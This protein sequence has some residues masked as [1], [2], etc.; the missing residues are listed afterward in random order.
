MVVGW[1][2][3]LAPGR[4][5][6]PPLPPHPHPPRPPPH[7]RAHAFSTGLLGAL[8]RAACS[9]TTLAPKGQATIKSKSSWVSH[10]PA[11]WGGGGA[12][13]GWGWGLRGGPARGG[14]AQCPACAPICMQHACA[15]RLVPDSPPATPAKQVMAS[16]FQL[17]PTTE[18]PPGCRGVAPT[19][20]QSAGAP[21]SRACT[22]GHGSDGD[23][24][25]ERELAVRHATLAHH[26]A[27]TLASARPPPTLAPSLLP[28]LPPARAAHR[29]AIRALE[30][31]PAR[32]CKCL[33]PARVCV[34]GGGGGGPAPGQRAGLPARK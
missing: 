20:V 17:T 1:R 6:L 26:S 14:R 24:E 29:G 18:R 4:R 30:V 8:T 16:G 7:L 19:R 3:T 15:W 12:G 23:G 27:H 5:S 25:G 33:G 9:P 13:S 34:G 32:Q 28:P 2:L 31:K 11:R 21:V 10:V 22:R